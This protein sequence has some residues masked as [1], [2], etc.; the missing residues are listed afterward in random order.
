VLASGPWLRSGG[1]APRLEARPFDRHD[2]RLRPRIQLTGLEVNRK[3]MMG[4]EF[5]TTGQV[6][7]MTLV[8]LY[9][10]FDERSVVYWDVSRSGIGNG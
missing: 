6:S 1:S 7:P 5:R 9:K 8:P 2:L 3:Y 4:L 10:L